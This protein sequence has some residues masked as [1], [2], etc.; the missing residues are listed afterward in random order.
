MIAI[1]IWL[2]ISPLPPSLL[3]FLP[4]SPQGY[5]T[6]PKSRL[7][8]AAK[9]HPELARPP[10]LPPSLKE[11]EHELILTYCANVLGDW[12]APS[13]YTP[14]FLRVVLREGGEEGGV[15]DA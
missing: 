11:G 13:D 3:P 5:N 7:F 4:P 8:Y 2:H 1:S 9:F 10:F 6:G 12:P 14:R 15:K